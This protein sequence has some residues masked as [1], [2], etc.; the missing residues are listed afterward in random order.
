M[1][2]THILAAS[3]LVAL[4]VWELD[5]AIEQALHT[6]PAPL[7]CP[8]GGMY[9]PSAV[10]EQLI[11]WAHTSPSSRH[12]GIGRTVAHLGQGREGLCFLLLGVCPV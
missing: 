8:I 12:P 3:Y 11:Y 7:Q 5:A 2:Q 10:R 6:E 4:V 9:V 1:D